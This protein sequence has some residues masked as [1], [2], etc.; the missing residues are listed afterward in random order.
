MKIRSLGNTRFVGELYKIGMLS[1]NI[2]NTCI[3]Q[4]VQS[5]NESELESLCKLI[6][7]IG[8]KMEREEKGKEVTYSTI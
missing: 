8:S 5:D 3:R 2:M 4:L 6:P 7:T 1:I